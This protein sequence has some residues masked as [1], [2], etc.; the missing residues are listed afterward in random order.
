MLQKSI[1][2]F[3]LLIL[4]V[5][6]LAEDTQVGKQMLQNFFK[7]EVKLIQ[8]NC[9]TGIENLDQWKKKRVQLRNELKEM[10]GLLPEPPRG[11]LKAEVTGTI[12]RNDLGIA[13]DKVHFQSVPKLYVTGN[14]YRP[15]KVEGKA[16]AILYLCGHGRVR[17]GNVSYGNKT[18]YQHHPTWFARMGY[19]CLVIDTIQLG[20]IEGIHHG[21]YRYDMWWW[22]SRGYT[23]GGVEAW[24]SIR[25]IDYLTQR[26]DVDPQ[27]I[28]VTG[29]SGGGIGTWWI[30][31]L[32][33][34]PQVFVPVAGLTDMED[35]VVNGVIEGHCDCMYP[36][37]FYKWD[38]A[39]LAALIAPRPLLF[40]NTDKDTIFPLDGVVRCHSKVRKIYELYNKKS[41]LGLLITEGPHKD[42][43]DLRVPAFNWFERWLKG[44]K[45][46]KPLTL[47]A[48]KH[49]DVEDL[50]VFKALPKDE[51]TTQAHEFFVPG[52]K[53][54][55]VPKNLGAL[56]NLQSKWKD[57]L[58][59][60]VLNHE[61]RVQAP[62]SLKKISEFEEMGL[63]V[64]GF[65]MTSDNAFHLPL[66]VIEGKQKKAGR[67]TIL[68]VLDSKSELGW[69]KLM[70]AFKGE[71][72]EK[73]RKSFA[74][75]HRLVTQQNQS[76][77]LFCPRG[78][79]P[80]RW[81]D[82]LKSKKA[83][84]I[85][86]RF[87][88]IGR[89]LEETYVL[90]IR[91]AIRA[92]RKIKGLEKQNITLYAE[93][94]M[95]TCSVYA[96][97]FEPGVNDFWFSNLP[98]SHRSKPV[99]NALFNVLKYLD[100]TQACSMLFPRKVQLGDINGKDMTWL[101]GSSKLYPNNPLVIF[102]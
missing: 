11:D 45:D 5:I 56:K 13:V 60:K 50:R 76:Y 80:T 94:N 87:S 44:K 97:I 49:F 73:N 43:Q 66:W 22:M 34:R 99:D 64:R 90:D 57:V 40:A 1:S 7:Q 48:E 26:P 101:S 10:L 100:L 96:G 52:F 98:S 18:H 58:L 21:T 65:E 24:N 51:K 2:L 47:T 88:L 85:R 25:A 74:S 4:P 3:T 68:H 29:R 32:D 93:R 55:T 12:V 67:K 75:V 70:N 35:H 19:V 54:P 23:P 31:A 82:D 36:V 53:A 38:F 83:N 61:D 41:H 16:P 9:L 33:D 46:G 78:V 14:V 6:G 102:E 79:G 8:E 20:E 59:K 95:A 15:L 37:N 30:A 28:G 91:R 62:L 71:R 39:N 27:R 89:A 72:T 63:V 42:T 92:T 17:K 86:R 77:I 81:I 69:R 84:Q